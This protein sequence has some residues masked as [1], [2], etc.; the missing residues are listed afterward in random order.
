MRADPVTR[1]RRI[2]HIPDCRS[3]TE[4][5][6]AWEDRIDDEDSHWH[7]HLLARDGDEAHTLGCGAARSR[8]EARERAILDLGKS[9]R[10]H[11]LSSAEAAA[12]FDLFLLSGSA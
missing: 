3:T 4:G 8:Q 9:I 2:S 1:T 5:A 7:C 10:S 6:L 11:G 12:L